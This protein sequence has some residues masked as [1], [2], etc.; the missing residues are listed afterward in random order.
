MRIGRFC[1]IAILFNRVRV[2]FGPVE[3]EHVSLP[4]ELHIFSVATLLGL[5]TR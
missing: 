5:R 3:G 2:L 1:V 4:Q